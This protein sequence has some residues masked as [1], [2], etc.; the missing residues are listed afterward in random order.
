MIS[1]VCHSAQSPYD[2][3]MISLIVTIAFIGLVVWLF[4]SIV[5]LPPPFPKLILVVAI[6]C[7]VFVVLQA[8]GI[9]RGVHDISVPQIR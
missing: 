8:F 7:A 4:T 1:S 6:I 3:A 9:F 5:P 2:A